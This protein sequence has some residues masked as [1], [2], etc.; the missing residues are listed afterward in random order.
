M[1]ASILLVSVS[2]LLFGL[3]LRS[4]ALLLLPDPSTAAL[5]RY[6][7]TQPHNLPLLLRMLEQDHRVFRHLLEGTAERRVLSLNFWCTGLW[8]RAVYRFWPRQA[9]LLLA[10]MALTVECFAKAVADRA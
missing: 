4:A 2:L 7:E 9:K 10:E 1:V 5:E 8:L 6:A 3:W